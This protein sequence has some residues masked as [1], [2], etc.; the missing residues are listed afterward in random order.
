MNDLHKLLRK[1]ET[2][3]ESTGLTPEAVCRAAT[4]NPRLYDRLKR[5]AAQTDADVSRLEKFMRSNPPEKGASAARHKE[6]VN[7]STSSQGV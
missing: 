4:R 5:R 3:A 7:A 1:V 2:Y 6:D